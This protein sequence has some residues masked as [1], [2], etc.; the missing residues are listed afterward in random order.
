MRHRASR[1]HHARCVA[2]QELQGVRGGDAGVPACVSGERA[3]PP[4]L[5]LTAH[6]TPLSGPRCCLSRH[7]PELIAAPV[8]P[9][10]S[11]ATRAER[12]PAGFPQLCKA[13]GNLVRV[14]VGPI[15]FTPCPSPPLAH[16]STS[17]LPWPA[18]VTSFLRVHI[19]GSG[20]SRSTRGWTWPARL[21]TARR[22]SGRSQ[23]T[24]PRQW[25]SPRT[26]R[27]SRRPSRGRRA[28]RGVSVLSRNLAACEF[29]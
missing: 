26:G 25:R 14:S 5:L 11:F 27:R 15:P 24:W 18:C 2:A 3:L 21:R 12:V 22:G 9:A 4:S 6:V 8:Y 19:T 7:F 29:V 1:R 16:F 10:L 20:A 13:P 28:R 23:R 17:F